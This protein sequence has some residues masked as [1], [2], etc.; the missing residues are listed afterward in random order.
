[1]G[2]VRKV[3]PPAEVR[4]N[5]DLPE[6]VQAAQIALQVLKR[7]QCQSWS[8]L[9]EKS[10][11]ADIRTIVILDQEQQDLID[12]YDHLLPYLSLSPIVTVI[13]CPVCKSYGLHDRKA[14]GTTCPFTLR[15]AGKPVK[16]PLTQRKAGDATE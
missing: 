11:S 4:Q 15:C 14:A 2:R 3:K 6:P 8:A 9:V 5:R 12:R 7:A 1:M 10:V 13:A 16:A